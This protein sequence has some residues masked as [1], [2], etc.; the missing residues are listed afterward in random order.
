MNEWNAV[1]HVLVAAELCG[2]LGIERTINQKD[3]G[4]RT[5][6]LVSIGA[7]LF[8]ATGFALAN[9]T[10]I[11]PTRIAAQVVTGGVLGAG[12]IVRQGARVR[13]LIALPLFRLVER[14]VVGLFPSPSA[15]HTD[16]DTNGA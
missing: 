9:G 4:V 15:S 1:L 10:S 13:Y 7:A 6:M 5:F 16:D 8:T 14:F 2:L 12:L 11:D 3:A